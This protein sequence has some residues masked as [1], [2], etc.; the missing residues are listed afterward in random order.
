M[1]RLLC[2]RRLVPLDRLDDYLPAWHEVRSA[3]LAS[4][5][6]AWLFR[7]S[8]HQDQFLEFIEWQDDVAPGELR[9]EVD[10]ARTA[11]DER[12]GFGETTDWEET[13]QS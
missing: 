9:A 12:F 6:R 4:G 1:R 2:T 10:A 13:D 3:A 7:R 8:D 5:C 11:L